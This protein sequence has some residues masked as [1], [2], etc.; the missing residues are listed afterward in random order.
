MPTPDQIFEKAKETA[1]NI[2][3]QYEVS[4]HWFGL[5]MI[6]LFL[7]AIY[8]QMRSIEYEIVSIKAKL[9]DQ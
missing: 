1:N 8:R 2:E 3:E 9:N 7:E 4:L 6:A 5:K